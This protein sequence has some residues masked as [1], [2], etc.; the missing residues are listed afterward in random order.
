MGFDT[1]CARRDLSRTWR[2]G[3]WNVGLVHI[4]LLFCPNEQG[5][6]DAD[7][8]PSNRFKWAACQLDILEHCLDYEEL[9]RALHSLPR[10][11]DETYYRILANIPQGC[12]EK[13]IRLLQFLVYS[14]RPLAIQEAVDAIA[15]RLIPCGQFNPKYRLPC[16]NEIT[17][18][19][20]SLVSLITRDSDTGTL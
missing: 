19:C 2:K 14:E 6:L 13:A 12:R 4:S 16:P 7:A 18:F 5:V 8:Y 11:L 15:I 1:R 17:R 9:Q 10:T 20:P 3:R